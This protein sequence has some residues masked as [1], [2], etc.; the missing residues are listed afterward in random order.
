MNIAY[1]HLKKY[2]L[3]GIIGVVVGVVRTI[4]VSGVVVI[5]VIVGGGC[6][7][8]VATC[9]RNRK[10][11][12]LEGCSVINKVEYNKEYSKNRTGIDDGTIF[13]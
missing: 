3:H 9:A 5:G 6:G 10:K 1:L 8:V 4:V 12:N 11:C 13:L 7:G 2:N